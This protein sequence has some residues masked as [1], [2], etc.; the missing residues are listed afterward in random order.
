VAVLAIGAVAIAAL[1]SNRAGAPTASPSG[2][3][4]VPSV[5]PPSA[6]SGTPTAAPGGELAAAMVAALHADPFVGHV[7]E[8]IVARSTAGT[9]TVTVTAKATGD[10]SGRDV[11]I[12]ATGTGAGPAVDR[13]I[14]S[15]GDTAWIR[16]KGETS[17]TVHPRSD[18]AASIDGLRT[19]IQLIDDPNQLV[20]SGVELIDGQ[21]LHHLTAFGRIAYRS[22]EGAEGAYDSFDVWVTDAGLPILAKASF[23]AAQGTNAIVGNT[24]IRYSRIGTAITI[25]PPAGAP[26]AAP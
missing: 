24:D 12:H 14:V 6:A 22:E 3:A 26:T 8:S 17:W 18:V 9:T 15:V 2:Q 19:T 23:S 10:I 13:E 20:D 4:V 7:D 21:A 5:T 25:V 1:G 11:A 16:A